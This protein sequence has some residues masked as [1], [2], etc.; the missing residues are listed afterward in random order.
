[1]NIMKKAYS[2]VQRISEWLPEVEKGG[3][4]SEGSQK[5]PSNY[6]INKSQGCKIQHSDYS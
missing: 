1:M 2:Q 4:M 5:F 6:K 3:Q